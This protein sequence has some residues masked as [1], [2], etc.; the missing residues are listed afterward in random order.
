MD[1]LTHWALAAC[2]GPHSCH[3][4]PHLTCQVVDCTHSGFVEWA[5]AECLVMER[6]SHEHIVR[7]HAHGAGAGAQAEVYHAVMDLV[8]RS[9]YDEVS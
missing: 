1:G 5:R 2:R 9:L 3:T 6:L 8:P 4:V 7:L